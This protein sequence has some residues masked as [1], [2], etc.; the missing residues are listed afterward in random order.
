[1]ET[2]DERYRKIFQWTSSDV[3]MSTTRSYR[4]RLD[5]KAVGSVSASITAMRPQHSKTSDGQKVSFSS[6]SNLQQQQQQELSNK[7]SRR[8]SYTSQFLEQEEERLK[9]DAVR[10]SVYRIFTNSIS[11]IL[12][13]FLYLALWDTLLVCALTTALTVYYHYHIVRIY[14]ETDLQEQ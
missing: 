3:S 13:F 5:S 11:S 14:I 1:M 2:L 7:R 10:F 4:R 9:K 8:A 6:S 12:V